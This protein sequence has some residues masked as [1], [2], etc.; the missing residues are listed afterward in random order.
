VVPLSSDT[1]AVTMP[2]ADDLRRGEKGGEKAFSCR[3]Y[4]EV[5]WETVLR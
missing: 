3:F 5:D 4:E 1:K 2:E